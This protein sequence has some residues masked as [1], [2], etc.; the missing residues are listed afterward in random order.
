MFGDFHLGSTWC[1]TQKR[2]CRV[3]KQYKITNMCNSKTF[4]CK[5]H[6]ALVNGITIL[7]EQQIRYIL[8]L[9]S[10]WLSV[11]FSGL[12]LKKQQR[13]LQVQSC[14]GRGQSCCSWGKDIL[15]RLKLSVRGRCIL[16]SFKFSCLCLYRKASVLWEILKTRITYS[17][18]LLMFEFFLKCVTAGKWCLFSWKHNVCVWLVTKHLLTIFRTGFV[19]VNFMFRN[20]SLQ[21][22]LYW[23]NWG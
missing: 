11:Q 15:Q 14:P 2:Y 21:E 22:V 20:S 16:D 7:K 8:I 1:L 13:V 4:S 6:L 12:E 17:L 19:H 5:P 23:Q 18:I 10:A 9:F 3:L